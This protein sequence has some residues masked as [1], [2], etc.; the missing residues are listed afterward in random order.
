VTLLKR[1]GIMSNPPCQPAYEPDISAFIKWVEDYS[2]TGTLGPVPAVNHPF[3]PLPRLETYLKEGSRT[4]T[5]LR[6]SF[7]NRDPPI[8]AQEVWRNCTKV[9]SILLFI[10]KGGFIQYFVQNEQLWDAKLPFIS[11]AD[12]P[13]TPNDDRFFD[14]FFK[15]QW[16]FCP[17]TFCPDDVR[18]RKECI[19]PIV[20]KEQLQGGG[21]AITY[22]IKLHPAYD[23]L[24]DSRQVRPA[25]TRY[26]DGFIC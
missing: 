23:D 26:R 10:G 1:S 4:E 21:S 2:V 17:H 11:P 9:F 20:H 5:L 8:E 24:T 14:S 7:P 18:L 6:A 19:L 3:M 16:R 13:H 22:K 15:Q 25:P 12:F